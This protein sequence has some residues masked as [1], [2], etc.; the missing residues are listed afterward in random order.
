[1]PKKSKSEQSYN[2]TAAR[3]GQERHI[4]ENENK[5]PAAVLFFFPIDTW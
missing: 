5:T 1:M 4:Y 2:N 3:C